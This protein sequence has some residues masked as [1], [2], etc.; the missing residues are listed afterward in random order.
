M[1]SPRPMSRP[2]ARS[3]GSFCLLLPLAA[4][5]LQARSEASCS[6]LARLHCL[7]PPA[8]FLRASPPARAA[9]PPLPSTSPGSILPR[10][11]CLTAECP[12][13][14]ALASPDSSFR[15]DFSPARSQAS[16]L[17]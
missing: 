11:R 16:S 17:S 6:L 2:A 13:S 10:T 3:S 14:W 7:L 12:R 8:T 4:D 9:I 1:L 15:L 5:S